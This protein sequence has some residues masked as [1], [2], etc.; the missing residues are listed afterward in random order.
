MIHQPVTQLLG[1]QFLQLLYTLVMKFDNPSRR[2]VDE[3]IV[4]F[5][6]NGLVTGAAITKCM[7]FDNTGIF[8]QLDGPVNG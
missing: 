3:M 4:M 6:R 2:K 5:F 8:K 1:D 7:A